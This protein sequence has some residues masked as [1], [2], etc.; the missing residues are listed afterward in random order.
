MELPKNGRDF[1]HGRP[2]GLPFGKALGHENSRETRPAKSGR[3]KKALWVVAALSLGSLVYLAAG[4]AGLIVLACAAGVLLVA[5]VAWGIWIT[6][7]VQY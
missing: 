6:N 5:A 1:A 3:F 4:T 2:I 7:N